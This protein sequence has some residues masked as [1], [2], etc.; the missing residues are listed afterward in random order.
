MSALLTLTAC[1]DRPESDPPVE[2]ERPV[3]AAVKK[4]LGPIS[5]RIPADILEMTV[6]EVD[7]LGGE[8]NARLQR[9]LTTSEALSIGAYTIEMER[10]GDTT[11]WEMT[12]KEY[13]DSLESRRRLG[14]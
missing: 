11:F 2:V 4:P 3:E 1:Q 7:Q 8:D 12:F 5:D 13:L 9:D 10:L 14:R 6:R